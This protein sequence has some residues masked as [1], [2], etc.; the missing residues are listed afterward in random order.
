[1]W[2]FSA[3]SLRGLNT[4]ISR[5]TEVMAV[6]LLISLIIWP[7]PPP[8]LLGRLFAS[9]PA[10]GQNRFPRALPSTSAE[11]PRDAGQRPLGKNRPCDSCRRSRNADN[12]GFQRARI[13]AGVRQ[14]RP[15]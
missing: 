5:R 14:V 8:I 9:I 12:T 15:D 4:R 13:L 1:M 6:D 7:S 11:K 10:D 3:N 2:A